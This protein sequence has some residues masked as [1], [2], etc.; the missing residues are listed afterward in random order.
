MSYVHNTVRNFA[1]EICG[2]AFKTLKVLFYSTEHPLK[3]LSIFV[4]F[5]AAV[6]SENSFYPAHRREAK[7]LQRVWQSFPCAC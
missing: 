7:Y 6:G 3:Y 4:C 2:K 5:F 1:C